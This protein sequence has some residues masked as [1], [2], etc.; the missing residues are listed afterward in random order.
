MPIR[1]RQDKKEKCCM[2]MRR[3]AC[4]GRKGVCVLLAVFVFIGLCPLGNMPVCAQEKQPETVEGVQA[5]ADAFSADKKEQERDTPAPAGKTVADLAE[6][7]DAEGN[8]AAEETTTE[9][10]KKDKVTKEDPETDNK[11]EVPEE[12]VTKEEAKECTTEKTEEASTAEEKGSSKEEVRKYLQLG[13]AYGIGIPLETVETTEQKEE[14]VSD[15]AEKKTVSAEIKSEKTAES[16]NPSVDTV[17]ANVRSYM[18]SVDTDPDYNSIWNVIGMTRS[19]L[20]VPASYTET[21]YKNVYAYLEEN[22]WILTKT[23]YTEYS[24]LI[25]ALTAI[26]KDAQ[27]IGGH[28][29]LANLSDFTDIK[30]QGFNGPIWALIALNSHPSYTIPIN[31][32][33]EEQTTEEGLIKY[34][35]GR[36]TSKGGWTLAGNEPD[37]DITGMTIQALA[38]Y[39]ETSVNVKGAI[40]RAVEWL[41]SVQLTSGGYA[42]MGTETSEST[43]QVITALSAIGID[44]AT[45]DRFINENGKWPLT[46]L[47]QYYLPEGGFMHVAAG[48][49]NNG[50]GEGGTLNGMATEQG[51]YATVAYKRMLQGKTAL[52]D[53]SDVTITA[54]EKVEASST[55]NSTGNTESIKEAGGTTT[56]LT[57]PVSQ[58]VLDYSSITIVKGKTKKLTAVA[59]PSNATNKE[60]KWSSSNKKV[61]TVTQKGK[62]KGVK[63]GSAVITVT[64]K[65]GSGIS[66]SCIV[67]VNATP[68]AAASSSGSSTGTSGTATTKK[69]GTATTKSLGTSS[70][71][72]SGTATENGKT[73]AGGWSFTGADYVPESYDSGDTIPLIT[74]AEAEVPAAAAEKSWQDKTIKLEIPMGS[75]FYAGV[76]GTGLLAFEALIWFIW[77]KRKGKVTLE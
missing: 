38:P 6:G 45:D 25:L 34:L 14:T 7:E 58:I 13:R 5:V 69:L 46:G 8:D 37:V 60:V 59:S 63:A 72:A 49:G 56:S 4:W 21:F 70:A 68:T 55:G 52:Y 18:L 15:K 74:E 77:K 9:E 19:G 32:D 47:F 53:M 3:T 40:N 36:E 50:G 61:A 42:T 27:N 29:L 28:N 22:N 26:G 62:V 12:P 51:M 17:L 41:A 73:E 11:T 57:V 64:A 33:A 35:L 10:E 24:K 76:G 48:A 39:Y 30:Y 23:K 54:G 2:K 65:D 1:Q 66:A 20:G 43:A 16:L 75:V 31:P 44:P 71:G 67:K